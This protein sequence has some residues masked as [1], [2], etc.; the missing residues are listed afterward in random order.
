MLESVYWST[1]K[2]NVTEI[3]SVVIC[4]QNRRLIRF[5]SRGDLHKIF[6]FSSNEHTKYTGFGR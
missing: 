5:I 1:C 2:Q 4:Q 3:C 6:L